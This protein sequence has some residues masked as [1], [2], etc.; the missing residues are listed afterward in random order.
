M[1]EC[2]NAWMH[3]CMNEWMNE[4]MNERMNEWLTEWVSEWMNDWMN[5]WMTEWVS[6]WVSEWMNEWMNDWMK[7][8]T[9][10]RP[11]LPKVLRPF[12]FSRFWCPM[13]LSLQSAATVSCAF[14]DLIVGKFFESDKFSPFYVKALATVV[15]TLCGPIFPENRNFLTSRDRGWSA[16][17][18]INSGLIQ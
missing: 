5:E 3:E 6:E 12:S 14:A 7:S 17:H 2:M 16:K 1:H 11:H 18:A 13:E 10:G 15:C 4:W 8:C 9:F